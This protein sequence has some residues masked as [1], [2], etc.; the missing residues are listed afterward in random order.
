M[1]LINIYKW[2][3]FSRPISRTY[4]CVQH[5]QLSIE[6]HITYN[7]EE[8]PHLKL[9]VI[10]MQCNL[11]PM[12]IIALVIRSEHC[13]THFRSFLIESHFKSYMIMKE[14]I[15]I[16]SCRI[17]FSLGFS[18]QQER[19]EYQ[20]QTKKEKKGQML[21]CHHRSERSVLYAPHSPSMERITK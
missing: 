9:I 18:A 15:T 10:V 2:R 12:K 21:I 14:F 5:L 4:V 13:T 8:N 6:N 7:Y 17:H 11:S 20:K 1:F 19:T 3:R 16:K